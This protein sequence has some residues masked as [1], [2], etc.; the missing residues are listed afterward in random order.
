MAKTGFAQQF[1][2][3]PEHLDELGHANNHQTKGFFEAARVALCAE[4]GIG[5][6][7]LRLEHGLG[8]MMLNDS[9]QYHNELLEGQVVNCV[10]TF[11]RRR[12]TI[13][14]DLSLYLW[15]GGAWVATTDAAHRM[16]MVRLSDRQPIGLPG[17][18]VSIVDDYHTIQEKY[19]REFL[20][21]APAMA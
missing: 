1:V 19:V 7:Y 20:R 5:R 21:N 13:T 8:L 10:P 3:G 16:A 12:A 6:T 18:V 9:Y 15:D 4:I 2:I 11:T 17:W 14:F